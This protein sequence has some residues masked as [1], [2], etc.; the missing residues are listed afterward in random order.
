M[1]A[2]LRDEKLVRDNDFLARR[3]TYFKLEVFII[4]TAA[5]RRRAQRA[6]NLRLTA[7]GGM[8]F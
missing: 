5:R 7:S 1:A 2:K 8:I 3:A 4:T 6:A